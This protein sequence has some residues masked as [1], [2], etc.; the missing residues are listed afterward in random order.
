MTINYGAHL[1]SSNFDRDLLAWA[2]RDI[3]LEVGLSPEKQ[4][5]GGRVTGLERAARHLARLLVPVSLDTLLA[6]VATKSANAGRYEIARRVIARIADEDRREK[7]LAWL[8]RQERVA[9]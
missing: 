2:E 7:G 9:A 5:Q 1:R 8:A 4:A 3:L 6:T